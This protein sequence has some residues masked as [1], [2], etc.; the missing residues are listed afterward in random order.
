MCGVPV[1]EEISN[2]F[3]AC[4]PEAPRARWESTIPEAQRR[5]LV[6]DLKFDYPRTAHNLG[7]SEFGEAKSITVCSSRYKLSHGT[8]RGAAVQERE[9]KIPGEYEFKAQ[10]ADMQYNGCGRKNVTECRAAGCKCCDHVGPIRTELRRHRLVGY[11]M[12]A[13]GEM[14]DSVHRMVK[15][16]APIGAAT[17]KR[18]LPTASYV[19]AC[20]RLAWMMKRRL[21]VTAV[22]AGAR[23]LLDRMEFIGPGAGARADR[24]KEAKR[25]HCRTWSEEARHQ[26]GRARQADHAQSG[27][28]DNTFW[29]D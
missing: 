12:G 8:K 27:G 25:R 13:Y 7:G 18:K 14:S 22:R 20:G 23:L 15:K 5:H 28:R 2:V 16:L 6:P 24:R 1:Q 29:D 19:S 21:G 26:H 10:T 4:M 11:V 17:W 9:R 3:A